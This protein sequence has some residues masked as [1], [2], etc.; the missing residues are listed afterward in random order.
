MLQN[1]DINRIFP[2]PNNPRADLGDLS[3]L[4]ESI[5]ENGI[6]QNLTVVPKNPE[7]YRK[8][9]A[10]EYDGDYVVIIGHRRVAA[11]QLAGLKEVLC[12]V[13]DMDETTQ[14][15]A[16]LLENGQRSDLT[17]YEQTRGIQLMLDLGSTVFD[18]SKKTGFSKTKVYSRIKLL[19]LDSEK[20]KAAEKRGATL[21]DYAE[22]DKIGD[23][24]LKNTVLEKIGTNNFKWALDKAVTEEKQARD[25]ASL[26]ETLS[27]FAMQVDDSE[28]Y[29]AMYI[30]PYTYADFVV[31]EDA[32]EVEYFYTIQDG[33][34]GSIY[35]LTEKT[36]DEEATAIAEREREERQARIRDLEHAH[37]RAYKLRMDFAKEVKGNPKGSDV[38]ERMAAHCLTSE[39]M[40]IV[41]STFTDFFGIKTKFRPSYESPKEGDKRFTFAETKEI[42]FKELAEKS[43]IECLFVAAYLSMEVLPTNSMFTDW[44]CRHKGN[45]RLDRLYEFLCLLGYAM[46]D[47]ELALQDGTHEL[48][49]S[50]VME[51]T[52]DDVGDDED[53][54]E[55]NEIDE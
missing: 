48:Y 40:R 29:R 15:A 8:R 12:A 51:E 46:S 13:A 36:Q 16:M 42:I 49:L 38:I 17:P 2:H 45:E 37:L 50:P 19:E 41:E 11:A 5:K 6:L 20:F 26:I 31:P 24:G 1:I 10:N 23:I 39:H 32:S 52:E 14:I 3:E 28:N 21:S 25:R 55:D 47:E 4:T 53:D 18:I 22:L 33:G 27:G 44:Q 54:F 43:T 34:S 7:E 35:L 9:N 30:S